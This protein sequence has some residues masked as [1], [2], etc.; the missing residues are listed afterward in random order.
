MKKSFYIICSLTLIILIY[1]NSSNYFAELKE[2][3]KAITLKEM[4]YS[5]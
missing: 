1:L 2:E 4:N 3:P 5:L